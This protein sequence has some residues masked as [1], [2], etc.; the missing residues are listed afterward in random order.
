MAL[1]EKQIA[2]LQKVQSDDIVSIRWSVS[3]KYAGLIDT[4][5]GAG[6][7]GYLKAWWDIVNWDE[8]GRRY[9]AR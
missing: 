3:L 7:P 1:T 9:D 6:R 5:G 8:A 4:H 2:A